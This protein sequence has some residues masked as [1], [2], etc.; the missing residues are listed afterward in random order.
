MEEFKGN[1]AYSIS[2]YSPVTLR[3]LGPRM[4][5]RSLRVCTARRYDDIRQN[6]H[7]TVE[8]SRVEQP[9]R[10]PR[11]C[12]F[13]E[14]CSPPTSAGL[15]MKRYSSIK[16]SVVNVEI[17][18]A[19]PNSAMSLPGCRFSR[20]TGPFRFNAPNFVDIQMISSG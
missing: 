10:H 16:P 14:P 9:K 8:P 12:A 11:M 20:A 13:E 6:K 17:V 4:A 7:T 5:R 19:P 15:T 1:P 3:R 2:S 18:F